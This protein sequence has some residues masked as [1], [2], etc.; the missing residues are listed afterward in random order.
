MKVKE[1]I[2]W[3]AKGLFVLWFGAVTLL[4]GHQGY[5][6]TNFGSIVGAVADAS[7]AQIP[8]AEVVVTNNGTNAKFTTKTGSGGTYSVLNLN[9]GTYTVTVALTGFKTTTS[10]QVD[11][12]VGGTARI[13]V[14]LQLG[15]I[16]ETVNVEAAAAPLQTD[17]ASLG[18]VVEGRQVLESPLNG[19]NVNNLLDFIPGVV[20][21]GGTA[22]NTMAN[23]GS[24][25]FQA[26]AQTQAIAYGNYQ[27]GGGF[28][29]Q[30]LFFIDGV[31]SN[32]PENNV[33]SLV[34]TQDAVQEFRVQTNNVSAEFGGFAGGVVQITT[35]SGTNQFHGS[36]YEYF[37]NTALDA[38]DWF[39]NHAGLP[40]SPLH[41]NQYGA[42]VGGP[43]LK[44]KLFF[45]FSFERESLTSGAIDTFTL[46]TTAEL[47]GDFSA[48][49]TPIYDLSTP[50]FPQFSCNGVLNVICPSRI[51]TTASKILALETPAPNRPGLVN[52]FVAVA[53][54][55]GAQNQYNARVDYT[56]GKADSLF[57]RYTFWNPHNGDSDPLGTKVGA[58]PTGN[59]TT[60]AVVGD[61]HVFNS[62]T[63]ADLRLSWLENYNFQVPLSNGFNQSTINANYG[64]LQ[65]QQVNNHQGLLPGLGVPGYS[66]GAELSQLYWLNTVYAIGGSLTKVKGRHTIKVGGSG[67]QVLWT[68]F[69]NN[70]GVGLSSTAAFTESP[71]NSASGNPLASLLLGI[72]SSVGITEVGTWRALLHPYGFYA[73]DTWQTTDKLTLNLGL[74]WDQPG[75]YSE[76]NNLDTILQPNLVTSL[77]SVTNPVTGASQPVV[78]GL[79]YVASPQ[80]PS[81][82]EEALHW[83]LFSPRLGFDYRVD[84]NTVVRGG[85]GISYL[86]AEIT[87][88]SPGAAPINN[89]GTGISNTPGATPNTTVANPFP[90]G[91]L[92]PSGRTAAALNAVLGQGIA[93][94]I[95]NQ[96]YGSAQQWNL[97]FERSIG[98]KTSFT[99]AY[100]GAKGTHLT[101]SQGFTGT[102]INLNQLPDQYDSIGG[103]AALGTGLFKPVSNPL[104][105]KIPT[106]GILGGTTI[107]EG[108]L[109]K[110]FPQY[111]GLTQTVPRDGWSNY[112]ALQATFQRHFSHNGLVQVAYTYS[113]LLSNTENTSSFEDGEGGLGVVQDQTNLLAE[114]SISMQDLT[115]NMVINYGVDLPFGRGQE[116]LSKSNG[117]VN[118]LVGGWRVNG[119]TTFHSGLPVP[120]TTSGNSLSNFFGSGPIRPNVVPGCT[121][122]RGGSQQSRVNEWFNTACYVAPPD[123]TFG[124]ESRVDSQARS[125]GAANFDFALHKIFKVY[126]QVTGNA[127]LETFNL[128]NRAQFAL[129]DSNLNDGAFGTVARQANLPRT[130]QV[131]LRFSF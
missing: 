108:Y 87:A 28:S 119:I 33:N 6:Q 4:S 57:A 9:P 47:N 23:G 93:S 3:L 24:G 22:G 15:D 114:G 2:Q 67:R 74:R 88:D 66:V 117:I 116:F 48:L 41:Q 30:S 7:G 113:K 69:G 86:P 103:S 27:I 83:N 65:A 49:S 126:E 55:E 59:T 97:G 123:F 111:T 84:T 18:G 77:G 14:T 96:K 13:D 11:V 115:Q 61:N 110:P 64:A 121:K 25:S 131:S 102:G 78:G 81:R 75:A 37:R 17:S 43:I 105:G 76:V 42:N 32:V 130:L 12:T 1:I 36:V 10:G 5:A 56:L 85:Y 99:V 112:Q 125:A 58:G 63:I 104:Y 129:P 70:Q 38:N 35:K 118:A 94:R 72:P 31:G 71:S 80:Y 21:G 52:N 92:L 62:S 109:L 19:R 51:D 60:A 122:K 95:P 50:G 100:A 79:V 46:P 73:T 34:P 40:R 53:P 45:F 90:N 107:L 124:N 20:P 26:G 101:L 89:A 127:S 120:F 44:N 98:T 16:S 39:S 128:F 68:N 91:I 8:G 106:G 29:G 82:R 54:I